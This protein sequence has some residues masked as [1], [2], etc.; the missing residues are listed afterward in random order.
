MDTTS[1]QGGGTQPHSWLDLPGGPSRL[2]RAVNRWSSPWT[3]P[4]LMLRLHRWAYERSDGRIG[5]GVG[6]HPALLLYTTGR[7][8]GQRRCTSLAY[9]RDGD[10]LIVVASNHGADKAPA[11][12]YNLQSNPMVEL[13][14]GR[15]HLAGEARVIRASDPDRGRLW[16][17]LNASVSGRL[18]A[19]QTRTSRA[20]QLVALTPTRLVARSVAP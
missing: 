17:L 15:V 14:V 2:S 6:G 5:H 18:D 19:Y 10:R 16:Q 7:R 20:I 12:L 1:A 9:A 4:D 13:Q 3:A 11:W 8:T